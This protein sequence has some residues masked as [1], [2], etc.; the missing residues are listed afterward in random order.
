MPVFPQIIRIRSCKL[1]F[2]EST[3]DNG[4]G[5]QALDNSRINV[6]TQFTYAP[7]ARGRSKLNRSIDAAAVTHWKRLGAGR[8]RLAKRFATPP[9]AGTCL[10]HFPRLL[11]PVTITL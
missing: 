11:P 2:L 10:T 4:H 9:A 8:A 7:I 3:T 1:W 6:C 5:L